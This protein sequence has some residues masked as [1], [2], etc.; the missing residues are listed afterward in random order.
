MLKKWV[1]DKPDRWDEDIPAVLMS[2][3]NT[4]HLS[5]RDTPYHALFGR[6]MTLPIDMLLLPMTSG[7]EPREAREIQERMQ[8]VWQQARESNLE[9]KQRMA[10]YYNRHITEDRIAVG[11]RVLKKVRKSRGK[12]RKFMPSFDALF[13]VIRLEPPNVVI[14]RMGEGID[15]RQRVHENDVKVFK[16]IWLEPNPTRQARAEANQRANETSGKDQAA[17]CPVCEET[18]TE[19]E[20]VQCDGCDEWYHLAC[21]GRKNFPKTLR[22]FCPECRKKGT[23]KMDAALGGRTQQP[24]PSTQDADDDEGS[25][26][27]GGDSDAESQD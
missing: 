6:D 24:S 21:V 5:I 25:E 18:G 23:H 9:A 14:Q 2:Y 27:Q 20:W 13:R 26:D 1:E 22:W 17:Q 4:V 10:N 12:N 11:D 8:S 16:G 7:E 3:R 19:G 15:K